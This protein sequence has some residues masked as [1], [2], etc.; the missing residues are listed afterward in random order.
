MPES[1]KHSLKSVG[2]TVKKGGGVKS[3][4]TLLCL[5]KMEFKSTRF[6]SKNCC[7]HWKCSSIFFNFVIKVLL[8]LSTSAIILSKVKFG[9]FARFLLQPS[10]EFKFCKSA[11]NSFGHDKD[12]MFVFFGGIIS[13]F[14]LSAF[15]Y[16]HFLSVVGLI[17]HLLFHHDSNSEFWNKE[18]INLRMNKNKSRRQKKKNK[19]T[20]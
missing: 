12:L 13:S 2:L 10:D 19:A 3:Q 5:D 6:S 17:T 15:L 7:P 11:I 8:T 9:K 14:K 1:K 18:M 16:I 20:K 4:I